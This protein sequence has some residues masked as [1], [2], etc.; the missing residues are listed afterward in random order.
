MTPL[1]AP[2]SE[3]V[4]K[5]NNRSYSSQLWAWVQTQTIAETKREHC[6]GTQP[7]NTFAAIPDRSIAAQSL[8]E[9]VSPQFVAL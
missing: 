6:V 8:F 9:H 3:I 2:L 5:E 1:G 7:G 4:S